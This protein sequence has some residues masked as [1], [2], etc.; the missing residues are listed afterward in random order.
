M[1]GLGATLG[2]L[3]IGGVFSTLLFGISTMQAY[4]YYRDYPKDRL[5]LK[6]MVM[7]IWSLEL[8]HSILLW[9]TIYSLTITFFCEPLQFQ[10]PPKPFYFVVLCSALITVIVQFFFCDR[11]WRFSGKKLVP[12]ICCCLSTLYLVGMLGALVLFCAH[13]SLAILVTYHWLPSA[14]FS[15]TSIIDVVIAISMCYWLGRVR[16]SE[17]P[18]TRNI[19]DTLI[20]WCIESTAAKSGASVIQLILFETRSDLLWMIFLLPKASL[21]S[22]SMLA[23]L[24]GRNRIINSNAD[25][26]DSAFITFS[27]APNP[28]PSRPSKNVVIQMTHIT[29]TRIDDEHDDCTMETKAKIE[30]LDSQKADNRQ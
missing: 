24:N 22:N 9:H 25:V 13:D 5:T 18:K 29:E 17:F 19:I 3:E 10:T 7:V 23:A 16:N 28:S 8:V 4:N 6:V 1:S 30:E 14:I 20:I 15:L 12:V 26:D 21:F 27:S 2:A 11:I